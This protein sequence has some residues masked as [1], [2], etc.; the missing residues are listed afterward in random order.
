M[1]QNPTRDLLLETTIKLLREHDDPNG[2]TVRDITDCAGV[3][4]S[5]VNYHFGS[6]DNLISEAVG[7]MIE[8][9]VGILQPDDSSSPRDRL[10]HFLISVCNRMVRYEGFTRA[11]IPGTLLKDGFDVPETIVPIIRECTE[12][13]E[14]ECRMTAYQMVS[15]LQ[16][17]FYRMDDL[18]RYLGMDLRDPK[19]IEEL[20]D[21]QM[22]IFLGAERWTP[23]S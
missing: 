7:R 20:I 17:V 12:C 23:W 1:K 2:I 9:E 5:L 19:V 3:N 15:F 4:V 16:L 11:V 18:G 13:S 8:S 21:R 6:K 10:R 22:D 14:T